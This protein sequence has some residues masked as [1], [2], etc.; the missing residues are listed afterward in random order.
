MRKVIAAMP[1]SFR[2]R[3]LPALGHASEPRH[4]PVPR[5]DKTLD[6]GAVRFVPDEAVHSGGSENGGMTDRLGEYRRK[7][8]PKRTPEP[9]PASHPGETAR[10][11][12]VIQQHHARALHWDVRL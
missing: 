5:N 10:N 2:T 12:F 6:H 11:R 9:I 3:G 1:P 4:Y 8:D 7:R